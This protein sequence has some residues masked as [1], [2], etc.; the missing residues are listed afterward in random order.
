MGRSSGI[1]DMTYTIPV[2]VAGGPCNNDDRTRPRH[3]IS[4]T[5]SR[6]QGIESSDRGD[7]NWVVRSRD[8]GKYNVQC[9]PQYAHTRTNIHN[10][11]TSVTS[12]IVD[13]LL[14][15]VI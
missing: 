11:I 3:T 13:K 15:C 7:V 5:L 14:Y 6:A 8:G 10:D 12:D 2:S 4:I 1:K 9:T